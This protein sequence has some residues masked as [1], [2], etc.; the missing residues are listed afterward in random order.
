MEGQ[1]AISALVTRLPAL[2]LQ[3]KP[4]AWRDNL[5]L[6]GLEALPLSFT[7]GFQSAL[8]ADLARS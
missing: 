2:S 4:L 8:A 3:P 7:P 5:G 1:I 6:R